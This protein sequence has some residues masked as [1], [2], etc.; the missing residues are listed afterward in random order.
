MRKKTLLLGNAIA[1]LLL[2]AVV[3]AVKKVN[4]NPFSRPENSQA[5]K[6]AMTFIQGQLPKG[7][8]LT[9]NKAKYEDGLYHLFLSV[10][11]QKLEVFLSKSGN[12]L[13]TQF[14]PL[15]KIEQKQP[16]NGNGKIS[17]KDKP[18]VLLFTMAF[19]PYG[20][21]A[22]EAMMPVVK[23]LGKHINFEP[24]YV[25]YNHYGEPEK[26]CFSKKGNYCSM[27]GKG[28]LYQDLRELCVFKNQKSNYWEFIKNIDDNCSPSNVDTCWL[29][30]AKEDHLDVEQ[31]N[32]CLKT[33]SLAFLKREMDLNKKYNVEGS[34]TLLINGTVYSG[35]RTPEAYKEAIC[36][37]FVHPPKEC[38]QKLSDSSNM[39]KASC[40]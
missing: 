15:N 40:K 22:E 1:L 13:F 30:I 6:R 26:F 39:G 16:V 23:L 35:K 19:C 32:Q 27:H 3:L 2:F 37:G 9:L 10:N 21:Q 14:I 33:D 28:E 11:N 7:N 18:D 29:G 25:F 4:I 20:N 31:I 12:L 8:K 17:Q 36:Q 38:G 5:V 24:H 34:P